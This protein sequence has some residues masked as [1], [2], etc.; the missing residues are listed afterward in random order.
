[1]MGQGQLSFDGVACQRGGRML[2]EGL[3]FALRPGDAMVVTGPNGV[4][5]SSLL[6]LAAGLLEPAGGTIRREGG[7]ALADEALALDRQLSLESALKFWSNIDGGSVADALVA[8]S[9]DHLAQVPV[10]MLS[11]GQRKRAV[12]ARVI[13]SGADI[14]LLDEPANGLDMASLKRL[15]TV[16]AN[17]RVR[18]G[19]VLAASHQSL[20]LADA[21][22]IRLEPKS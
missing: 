1:M 16:I 11:T 4:G 5:K 18:G 20:G 22:E 12:L 8:V 6:R 13:A 3:D 9:L 19:I 10:R 14:W 2:F 21:Q 17:H 7:I 15:S